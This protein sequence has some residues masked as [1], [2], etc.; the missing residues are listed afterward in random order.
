MWTPTKSNLK[1]YQGSTFKEVIRWESAVKAYAPITG[2]TK[3]APMVVTSANHGIQVGW[4][5]KITNVAGMTEVNSSN[6][7]TPT[8]VGVNTLTFA[9]INSLGYKDYTSGGVIEYNT[10]NSLIGVTAKMQIKQ[11]V[12]STTFYDELTTE[13]G[14][15]VVDNTAKTITIL[16][17]YTTTAAYTFTTA[18]YSL[19]LTVN[20]EVISLLY[21]DVTLVK[22]ITK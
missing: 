7:I 3:A 22:E 15:I 11:K 12:D 5:V 13:N 2:I 6:Y 17:D 21:G 4:R 14:K 18:V 9:D 8:A 19:E 20:G 16:I 10:P 1:I